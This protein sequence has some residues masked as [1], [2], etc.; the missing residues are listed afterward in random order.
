MDSPESVDIA[1][2]KENNGE[3]SISAPSLGD[4]EA[5]AVIEVNDIS[6]TSSIT[7]SFNLDAFIFIHLNIFNLK[8]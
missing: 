6:V 3:S 5:N 4:S 8:N 7:D 1:V 2:L